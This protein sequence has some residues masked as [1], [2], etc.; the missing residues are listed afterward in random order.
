MK[1]KKEMN[2]FIHDFGEREFAFQ[3]QFEI[4]W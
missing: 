3:N 1:W 2:I 4:F